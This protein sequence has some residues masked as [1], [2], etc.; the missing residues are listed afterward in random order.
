MQWN[1][2]TMT[3]VSLEIMSFDGENLA[4]A[5][6]R[7]THVVNRVVAPDISWGVGY[8]SGVLVSTLDLGFGANVSTPNVLFTFSAGPSVFA[9][10]AAGSGGGGAIAVAGLHA[11]AGIVLPMGDHVAARFEAGR[12]Y[13][14][15]DGES[16]GLW[17]FGFGVTGLGRAR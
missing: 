10:F 11:R 2:R 1:N 16:V 3:G 17:M 4:M 15:S 8:T 14:F 12:R 9:A 6:L 13:F 5:S 7:S